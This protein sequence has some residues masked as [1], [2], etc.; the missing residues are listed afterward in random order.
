MT[1]ARTRQ[2][3]T[4]CLRGTHDTSR[5]ARSE[6]AAVAAA[7]AGV[8]VAAAT[9]EVLAGATVEG[10]AALEAKGVVELATA[11]GT[12][13]AEAVRMEAE[14]GVVTVEAQ[15]AGPREGS[16]VGTVGVAE[17]LATCRACRGR[18]SLGSWSSM[19]FVPRN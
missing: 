3:D 11:V 12:V 2:A 14:L 16:A 7:T 17:A 9:A 6:G 15:A 1:S 13:G 19:S 5:F 4:R 10:R 18:R 8:T